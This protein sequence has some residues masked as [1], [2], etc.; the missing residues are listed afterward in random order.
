MCDKYSYLEFGDLVNKKRV[1][2]CNNTINVKK[3]DQIPRFDSQVA[4]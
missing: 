3:I 4:L 1:K 2:I